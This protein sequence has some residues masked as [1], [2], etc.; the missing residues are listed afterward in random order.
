MKDQFGRE[1][2]V[3]SVSRVFRTAGYTSPASDNGNNSG[4]LDPMYVSQ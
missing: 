3:S 2:K 4:M 1:V